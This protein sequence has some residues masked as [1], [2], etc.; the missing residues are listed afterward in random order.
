MHEKVVITGGLGFIGSNLIEELSKK[1]F[2]LTVFDNLSTGYMHNIEELKDKVNVV[3]GDIRKYDEIEKVLKDTKFVF[4]LAAL[5]YVGESIK[6]PELYFD[7]NTNGTY[8]VL[9]ACAK[10]SVGRYLF[11]ST[12]VVYGNSPTSPTPETESLN[13]TSPY[14][15]SKVFGEYYAKYFFEQFG[16][17]TIVLRVFNAYGEKMKN[18]AISIFAEQMLNNISP[19]ITGDGNQIRDF[20]HVDDIVQGF[21]KAM[22]AEKKCCGKQYNIGTGQGTSLNELLKKINK[23]LNLDIPIEYTGKASGEVDEIIADTELSKK[24][25][26]FSAKISLDEGLK[27][28]LRWVKLQKK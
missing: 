5:S 1:D 9:K 2:E 11:P 28:Y 26:D 10:N 3:N 24:E 8:N 12:C 23:N 7:V 21:A 6:K 14:G 15:L 27:K 18:R 19:T 13:P 22:D 4:N 16:L 17:E 25:L 20:V